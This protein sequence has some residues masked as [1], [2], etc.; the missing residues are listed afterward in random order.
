MFAQIATLQQ[1]EPNHQYSQIIVN[2]LINHVKAKAVR[3][4]HSLLEQ[5]VAKN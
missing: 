5:A 4:F 1:N 2:H 3:A